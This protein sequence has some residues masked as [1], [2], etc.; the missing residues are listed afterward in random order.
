[1]DRLTL[2]PLLTVPFATASPPK[3][4][5]PPLTFTPDWSDGCDALDTTRPEPPLEGVL[6]ERVPLPEVSAYMVFGDHEGDW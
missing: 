5:V 4:V 1:V 6:N 2:D 3:Y